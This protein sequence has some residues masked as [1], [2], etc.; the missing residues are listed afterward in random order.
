MIS[1]PNLSIYRHPKSHPL[2]SFLREWLVCQCSYQRPIIREYLPKTYSL[3][4][5]PIIS[6]WI[7]S[8]L[9]AF[10]SKEEL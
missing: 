1:P 10:V 7:E 3:G 9:S 4:V 6:P 8:F 2:L 5:P